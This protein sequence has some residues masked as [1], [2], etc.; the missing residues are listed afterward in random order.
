MVQVGGRVEARGILAVNDRAAVAANKVDQ[1]ARA[2]RVV[3]SRVVA[4]GRV[5]QVEVRAAAKEATKAV[6]RVA[7]EAGKSA[8]QAGVRVDQE[9]GKRV[10]PAVVRVVQGEARGRRAE[11]VSKAGREAR[12]GSV[13]QARMR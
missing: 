13:L 1:A 12:N 3:V 7:R 4:V 6:V 8:V 5:D 11:E 9:A 2:A 10:A